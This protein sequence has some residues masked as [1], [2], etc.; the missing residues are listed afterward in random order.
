MSKTDDANRYFEKRTK[1]VYVDRCNN[2][3]GIEPFEEYL[4]YRYRDSCYYYSAYALMGLNSDDYLV[5]GYI[6]YQGKKNYAHG[7]VEFKFNGESYVFDSMIIGV[8]LKGTWE[9]TFN[10]RVTYRKK[11]QEIFDE[12]LTPTYAVEIKEGF[13][14]F[15]DVY[16]NNPNHGYVLNALRLA[17]VQISTWQRGE[18]SDFFA[19]FFGA[20]P[21]EIVQ[22]F[23]AYD[24]P[25]V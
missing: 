17:R 6:N 21:K 5:R 23:I 12:Y 3:K 18:H 7:W 16:D 9:E 24:E 2:L 22:R 4:N 15:K 20:N 11:Q 10:P 8:V 19:K 25:S 1:K 14:Q 13:W